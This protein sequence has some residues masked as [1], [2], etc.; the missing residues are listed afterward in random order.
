MPGLFH[1]VGDLIY[2]YRKEWLSA[3]AVPLCLPCTSWDCTPIPSHLGASSKSMWRTL[4]NCSFMVLK[5]TRTIC[6]AIQHV[7]WHMMNKESQLSTHLHFLLL[8]Q[9]RACVGILGNNTFV[10]VP[11]EKRPWSKCWEGAFFFIMLPTRPF[12]YFVLLLLIILL[13]GWCY[14]SPDPCKFVC[15]SFIITGKITWLLNS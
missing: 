9:I 3:F 2:S 4:F 6:I 5:I 15:G 13:S 14:F 11:A 10:I 7:F 1:T 12:W 8:S